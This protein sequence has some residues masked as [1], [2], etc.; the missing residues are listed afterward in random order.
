MR[1][2]G[3]ARV[4]Q[5][6]F[7]VRAFIHHLPRRRRTPGRLAPT[8]V[9]VIVGGAL[10]TASSAVADS[11]IGR[12]AATTGATTGM[13]DAGSLTLQHVCPPATGTRAGCAME[14]LVMGAGGNVVHPRLARA[15]SPLR[16]RSRVNPRSGAASSAVSA[17]AA[18]RP[19]PGTPSYLQQAYELAFLSQTVG[20]S[21][22]VA[23]VDAYDDLTAEADLAMYRSTFGLGPCTTAD[24]CFRKVNQIG[25]T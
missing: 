9:A 3:F 15:S 12:V 24:S 6:R 2:P 13:N 16:T 18:P 19:Q 1:F 10:I 22:T 8:I 4:R 14:V 5:G 21:D 17:L 20:A 7:T 23:V 11:L 25:G